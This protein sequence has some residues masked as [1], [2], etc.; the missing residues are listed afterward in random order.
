MER[1]D[2][3][4]IELVL[5]AVA[6]ETAEPVVGVQHVG[7]RVVLEMIDHGITELGDHRRQLLL[8]KVVRTRRNVDDAMARLDL[9]D[10]GKARSRG[11]RVCR[12]LHARL[13]ER[14]NELA[15]VHVHAATVA[16]T[17]LGQGR[18]VE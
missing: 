17:R 1:A 9:H 8:G 2:E 16:R 7:G 12:A 15:H 6:D 10:V 5:D 3:R 14:R 13:R 4:Q 11:P 18:R